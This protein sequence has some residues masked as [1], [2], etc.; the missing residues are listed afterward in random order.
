MRK[1]NATEIDVESIAETLSTLLGEQQVETL[2]RSA[3]VLRRK[4]VL[5]T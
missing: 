4:R 5:V 2:S 3:G 1:E